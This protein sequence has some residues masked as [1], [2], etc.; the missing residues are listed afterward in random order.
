VA[1][2]VA[3]GGYGKTVLATELAASLGIAS[4]VVR[5][6]PGDGE[7]TALVRRMARAFRRSGLSDAADA[8]EPGRGDP[9]EAVDRLVQVLAAGGDPV[10]VVV[11]EVEHAGEAG[12]ELLARLAEDLPPGHRMLLVGRTVPRALARLVSRPFVVRVEQPELAFSDEEAIAL[13]GRVGVSADGWEGRFPALGCGWPVASLLAA[14]RL[15]RASDPVAELDRLEDSPALVTG[16]VSDQLR[17]LPTPVSVAVEQL[18]HLPHLT[19]EVAQRVSGEHDVVERAAAAGIPFTVTPDG[20]VDL[21]DPVRDVL[22]AR[23]PLAP[24][25]ARR[26][27][28]AYVQQGLGGEAVRV[29]VAAGDDEAAA[30]TAA[31]LTPLDVSRFDFDGLRALLASITPVALERHPR[32][33]LHLARACEAAAEAKLRVDLLERVR[34]AAAGDDVLAREVG[35]ELARDLVR[36]GRVDEAAALAERLLQDVGQDELQTRVRTLHVLGRTQAWR[37]DRAGLAAAEPMLEEAA[38]LYGRLGF[39]TQRAHALLALAYDVQTL[40]GRFE[41]AVQTLERA[42]AGLPG[43]SRLRGVVLVFLAEALIDLGR[44]REAE[45]GLAEAERLGSLFGDA[46][47][48]GYTWWLHARAGAPQGHAAAVRHALREAERHPGEWF[49][50]HSGAEFLAEAAVLADQ[51]GDV[52]LSDAYLARALARESEAPR[53]V[54]LAAG[55]I[56]AR[57]GDPATAETTL[58]EVT[59]MPDLELRERWRVS[60][61]RGWAAHRA[62]DEA[63]AATFAREAFDVVGRT[64]APDLPLRREPAIAAALLPLVARHVSGEAGD[65]LAVGPPVTVL[66]LGGFEVRRGGENV[67]PPAGRPVSLVKLLA[68]NGG[69]LS[70]DAVIEA[71]WPGV[72]APSGRKR[73]RN[74]LNRLREAVGELVVRRG[75]SLSLAPGAEVDAELFERGATAA[76]AASEPAE[77]AGRARAALALYTGDAL[78]DDRYEDWAAGPRERLR[79][80]ALALL[81]L[82]ADR[83]EA[84]GEL[85]EAL[86]LLGRAIE[87]DRIDESRY[88]RSARLLLHQGKR[89]RALDV[90]RSGA[91]ALRELGLEPSAEHRSL[92]RAARA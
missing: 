51:I 77:A 61:L 15:A 34:R 5:L 82:L 52:D 57:R 19:L 83:A 42:L 55:A 31:A 65:L 74:V 23:A 40:G 39:A 67:V 73:L 63:A 49:A 79:A 25:V 41:A 1:T 50:H 2:V 56:E 70:P 27:A 36:D 33:L 20:R 45:V 91:G 24:E 4:A 75:D 37:G 58:A 71:L 87:L 47:T 6:E 12:C 66:V 69:R 16:L 48:L 86:R 3:G 43:R 8:L 44:L 54:K 76:L 81:D 62:G 32:A 92:V 13:L 29:L 78:P 30:A 10:L 88:L 18:G 72:D 11:D 17:S 59:A 84:D 38:E 14:E 53:Y 80:R 21:P 60:L 35:A 46:R 64:G 68:L 26:A 22:A 85:D 9:D 28:E 90:L 7:A 89:G